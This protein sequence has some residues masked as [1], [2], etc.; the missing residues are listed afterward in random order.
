MV[1]ELRRATKSKG[2]P[3]LLI[4]GVSFAKDGP[5]A[6]E[7][8]EEGVKLPLFPAG[9]RLLEEQHRLVDRDEASQIE[10]VLLGGPVNVSQTL[11]ET[12]KVLGASQQQVASEGW[13]HERRGP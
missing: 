10:R 5:P 9:E 7:S 6:Y 2:R 11:P 13:A 1:S 3:H 4:H 12:V 8:S